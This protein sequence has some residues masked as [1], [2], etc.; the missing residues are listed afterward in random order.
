MLYRLAC[1]ASDIAA[2]VKARAYWRV[3]NRP[4]VP[5]EFLADIKNGTF[6]NPVDDKVA[7]CICAPFFSR[8]IDVL[9]VRL[10]T[11]NP[12]VSATVI[13]ALPVPP[14]ARAARSEVEETTSEKCVVT[15]LMLA[16]SP[17]RKSV[18]LYT[19]KLASFS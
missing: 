12:S 9:L 13:F 6:G 7:L 17:L 5:L 2:P 14:F 18:R 15:A 8:L 11:S 16:R 19:P 1:C 3:E 4:G 10:L